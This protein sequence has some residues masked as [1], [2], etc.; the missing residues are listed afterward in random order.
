MKVNRL[1]QDEL[2]YELTIRGIGIGTC[3]QMRS[4]LSRAIQM[5]KEGTRL[6]R[7]PYPYSFDQDVIAI[8]DKLRDI[9]AGIET[10]NGGKSSGDYAKW[11]TK[12]NHI[13]G[14]IEL[15]KVPDGDEDKQ[16]TKPEYLA[17]VFELLAELDHRA[18]QYE[19]QNITPAEISILQIDDSHSDSNGDEDDESVVGTSRASRTG[20]VRRVLKSTPVVRW[21][22][23]F[24]GD[25]KGMSLNAFLER[26]EE[27]R[28]AR[29]VS[30][31]ELFDTAIDLFQ[32]KAL[33][34]Y[35]AVRR[36]VDNWETL[37]KLL[38]EEFQPSDYNERLIEEIKRRTQGSDESIGIYLS[39]MSAMFSRLTCA[40]TEKVQLK[41]I[42]RNISPFYQT[43]LGL[44]DITSIAQLRTLGRRL[45]A[46]REA[47]EA[48]TPP[49]RK[50][51]NS[52][53]PDLAYVGVASVIS[54][55]DTCSTVDTRGN[56]TPQQI[57][58]YNCSKPGHR[59]IGCLEK[60]RVYCYK[61]KK[62]GVTTRNCP[63]CTR[64]GNGQRR[65]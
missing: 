51:V 15:I 56:R 50:N 61:C 57:L 29:H 25:K 30:R 34:W 38:R 39:I 63:N 9:T 22:L 10:F 1:A 55:E 49:A 7:P 26:V 21:N 54:S 14:R 43:Q 17:K 41:I 59:A 37:V 42:M 20:T 16:K 32:G 24:S 53:E 48:F 31:E 13:L 40:V 27:L 60:R 64:Q 23:Q 44:T 2:T 46:R 52:L 28:I 33:I 6:Q 18:D 11:E 8:A 4:A 65:S 3:E 5:E 12:L 58:C 36:E 62:E 35:R 19:S 45:E 47:V